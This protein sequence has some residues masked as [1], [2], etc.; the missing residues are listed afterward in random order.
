VILA[1]VFRDNVPAVSPS[2]KQAMSY[3]DVTVLPTWKGW[4]K[5]GDLLSF[6][7]PGGAVRRGMVPP[8]Y[9]PDDSAAVAPDFD[10]G[11]AAGGPYVLLLHESRGNETQVTP[12][13]KRAGSDGTQGRFA[14]PARYDDRDKYDR[15]RPYRLLS[16]VFLRRGE[17]YCRFGSKL[18]DGED[19]IPPRSAQNQVRRDAGS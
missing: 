17:R 4:H 3:Y 16:R 13:L 19:P 10:W 12:G 5:V 18:G 14:L 9:G 6:A 15:E 11:D 7:L 8:E 1:S 2:G